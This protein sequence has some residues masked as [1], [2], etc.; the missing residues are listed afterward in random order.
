MLFPNYSDIFDCGL[1]RNISTKGE[2]KQNSK[3]LDCLGV[4][5]NILLVLG[6]NMLISS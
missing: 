3:N 6:K 5:N 1:L 2:I 4:L